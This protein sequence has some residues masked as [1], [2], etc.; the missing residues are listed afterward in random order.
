ML[1]AIQDEIIKNCSDIIKS[2][3]RRTLSKKSLYEQDSRFKRFQR[4]GELIIKSFNLLWPN[5]C[6]ACAI[7]KLKYVLYNLM[8]QTKHTLLRTSPFLRI[9]RKSSFA[10]AI[11][12]STGDPENW[13]YMYIFLLFKWTALYILV[14]R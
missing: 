13:K 8:G 3:Y 14:L 9:W 4:N 12:S 5:F 11:R 10:S 7:P 6:F 1:N 2:H